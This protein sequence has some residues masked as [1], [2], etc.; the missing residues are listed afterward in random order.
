MINPLHALAFSIYENK[1]VYCIL[2]GSG[3][4]RAA[5]I[6]T[7]WEITLDLV[8]RVAA[9]DGVADQTDWAVWYKKRYKKEP[10]YSDLLD[11]LA[12]TPSERRAILHGYIEPT[13][14]DLAAG[15]KVPT[16]AHRAI[17]RLVQA[18][19]VRIILTTNFDRLMENSLRDLGVEPTVIV[20][21]DAL[22]GAVPLIHS[23]CYVVK[24]HGDY[25]DTRI[26]NTETELSDY[27]DSMNVL[28][29]RVVDEHGMIVSGWSGDWDSALRDALTRAPNR[30][31]PMYWAA[32]GRPSK[33]ATDLIAQR[34][35]RIIAIES[36][37]SFFEQIEKLV[38]N[39]AVV[40]KPNPR[41][42]ELMIATAKRLQ[43][44]PE[45]RIEL[46]DLIGDEVRGISRALEGPD[47]GID[48]NE[49]IAETI[50]R[51][52]GLVEILAR[53]LSVMGK[54]GDGTE[55]RAVNQVLSQLGTRA[56]LGG[57]TRLIFLRTYPGVL[58]LYG[59]G[60]GL[61]RGERY[62]DLFR[63]FAFELA[64]EN[65]QKGP[66]VD[67]LVLQAWEGGRNEIFK[68]IPELEKRRTPLSDRLHDVFKKWSPD[69]SF[70]D[71][72]Y[73]RIFEEFE[74]LAGL[75]S[76]TLKVSKSEL[77]AADKV[78]EVVW[79]PI[80]RISWDGETHRKITERWTN[81]ELIAKLLRAGF[82]GGDRDFFNLAT[83]NMGR[84]A[85]RMRFYS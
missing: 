19:Y 85:D 62:D 24:L 66:V 23:R 47:G 56:I 42:V 63:S 5:N 79:C 39:Q 74:F 10:G 51:Y 15:R 61:M 72:D 9:L 84:V 4:S 17:A 27:T 2:L 28:L 80:G 73:T 18:G 7:G 30:R 83:R 45:H 6:P 49:R 14:E 16:I 57:L 68:A 37:D 76:I 53:V 77:T 21:E 50:E 32:R 33:I 41:S 43:A 46:D 31:Y 64:N 26:L 81:E 55:S 48:S 34:A 54:W 35:G 65:S 67:R 75:A 1:G 82:A 20:S 11:Q 22:K 58:A 8:R 69:T 13:G 59:Y 60:L 29:D 3:V 36:A 78:N 12:A 71:A 40:N 52:E 25:L 44:R 38:S 70:V